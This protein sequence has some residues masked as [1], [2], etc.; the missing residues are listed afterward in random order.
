MGSA[1]G[2]AEA[3]IAMRR[4]VQ[5][6]SGAGASAPCGWAFGGTGKCR[7][8]IA[9]RA[10]YA[11]RHGAQRQPAVLPH[12]SQ[13]VTIAGVNEWDSDSRYGVV[14]VALYLLGVAGLAA[15]LT[16]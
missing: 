16:L 1:R 11:A 5:R 7:V 6:R 8:W 15:C 4:K 12:E 2:L 3:F 13:V 14:D 9:M 10:S